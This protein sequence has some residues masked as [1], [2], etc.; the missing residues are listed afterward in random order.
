MAST[1]HPANSRAG[2]SRDSLPSKQEARP[3]IAVAREGEHQR[4]FGQGKDEVGKVFR[5]SDTDIDGEPRR[6]SRPCMPC[7]RVFMC[8]QHGGERALNLLL[9]D[10][11]HGKNERP[12]PTLSIIVG[13]M[14]KHFI[15]VLYERSLGT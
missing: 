15:V 13:V 8:G 2:S 4:V 10:G 14:Y 6:V 1:V 3:L 12:L 11:L 5:V 9:A 7:V